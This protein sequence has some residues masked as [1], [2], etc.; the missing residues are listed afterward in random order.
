MVAG[1]T[2]TARKLARACGV[3]SVDLDAYVERREGKT[4]NQIF[5][6][7]GEEG[8]RAMETEVLRDFSQRDPLLISCGGGV[9]LKPENREILKR[10]GFAVYLKVTA[11]QAYARVK[12]VSSR[13]L[14]RDLE[15]AR[16]TIDGRLPLYEEVA[17][18]SVDTAGKSV[19]QVAREVRRIL[20]KEGVLCLQRG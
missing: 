18:A 17:D 20:E 13:P 15:T 14:F 3:A 9:V 6:E 4:I 19:A 2:S 11:E 7:A 8:F 5:S 10:S 1:K 16:K 12:D